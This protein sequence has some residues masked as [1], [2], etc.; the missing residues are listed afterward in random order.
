MVSPA[1]G[2]RIAD[3]IVREIDL[4]LRHA[5]SRNAAF[6]FG[7]LLY[8]IVLRNPHE[9]LFDQLLPRLSDES[10]RQETLLFQSVIHAV[11]SVAITNTY[12]IQPL[13]A[14][15]HDF[16]HHA[17]NTHS[18]TIESLSRLLDLFKRLVSEDEG[19][20]AAIGEGETGGLGALFA[21]FDELASRVSDE[22][23][24]RRA[25]AP[26]CRDRL[27]DLQSEVE[28][29]Q[30]LPVDEFEGRAHTVERACDIAAELIAIIRDDEQLYMPERVFLTTVVHHL[31]IF[32]ERT[33]R[34]YCEEP[35][36]QWKAAAHDAFWSLFAAD[37]RE[38]RFNTSH[39]EFQREC[40][41]VENKAGPEPS[42]YPGQRRRFEKFFVRWVS[43]EI[44]AQ[45]LAFALQ[46][47]WPTWFRWVF[48]AMTSFWSIALLMILPC[49][50]AVTMHM[51][52]RHELEGGGF[53][54]EYVG[55]PIAAVVALGST[56]LRLS[57]RLRAKG[58]GSDSL[59][60]QYRFRSMFPRVAGFIA[61]PMALI[62]EFEHAYQFPLEASDG[63]LLL[64]MLLAFVAI[65]F[66]VTNAVAEDEDGKA[67]PTG[68][69]R[70]VRS[71]VAVALAQSFVIA[72]LLSL[73]FAGHVEVPAPGPASVAHGSPHHRLPLFLSVL[74][75]EVEL[76]I[77]S[78][79][80]SAGF[81]VEPEVE[82]L[83]H[84]VFYPTIILT[85]TALG[86]LFGVVFEGFLKGA[87]VRGERALAQEA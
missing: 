36:R 12:D 70:R 45:V 52:G 29:Y 74:P 64:L 61:A 22:S 9:G 69:K 58:S 67:S 56:G 85:W 40:R 54:V 47:R 73:I 41:Q 72:L 20:W 38:R 35:Q 19:V 57:R 23:E 15:A 26:S 42:P 3:I 7:S 55:I 37:P 51:S 32:F 50:V 30:R 80:K 6:D 78:I 66:T 1:A 18:P 75:R 21:A 39:S 84:F 83:L 4:R 79:A 53:F 43:S 87:K 81:I 63:S 8:G 25:L 27:V 28:F 44:D 49:M 59:P 13:L 10:D 24:Q 33:K 14:L 5:R 62:V 11:H 34:W 60:A 2:D 68:T 76:D 77:P 46:S 48:T 31:Q 65:Q 17:E 86:V 82:H 71:I 16:F